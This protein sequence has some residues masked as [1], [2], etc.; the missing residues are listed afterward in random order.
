MIKRPFH[1]HIRDVNSLDR[2]RSF[3]VSS[4]FFH[5]GF[6]ET[7][8]AEALERARHYCERAF[9]EKSEDRPWARIDAIDVEVRQC[10]AICDSCGGHGSKRGRDGKWRKCRHCKGEPFRY[11]HAHGFTAVRP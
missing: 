6:A 1:V 5:Y 8:E 9:A 7:T 11:D 2:P 10:V 4:S 3:P